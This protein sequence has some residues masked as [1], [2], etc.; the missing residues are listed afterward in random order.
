MNNTM[1]ILPAFFDAHTHT[2]FAAYDDDRNAVMA[3]A[4]DTGVWLIN[5]GTE[6]RTSAA[7]IA[8]AHRAHRGVWAT[9]GLHPLHAHESF[10]DAQELGPHPQGRETLEGEEFNYNTYKKLA[11]DPK[12]VG[13]GECGLDHFRMKDAAARAKQAEVF[14][15]HIEL[16]AEIKK[17]LM[18]HCREA[19]GDLISTLQATNHKL[20]SPP[21]VVHFFSGTKKDAK[22]LLDMEF[23][24]TF[25]G[26]VTFAREYDEVIR[27]LPLDHI[28][29]ETD[30]PYVSPAPYR[31]KRNEPVYI[32][33]TV[34][35]IADIRNEDLAMVAEALVKNAIRT[36]SIPMN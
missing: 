31:G 3:R 7:A 35:K 18:I 20:P 36:F 23:G 9:V 2:Q 13:I 21:G 29:S 28:L 4:R 22:K 30:A 16:S 24:F 25:G 33:E 34:K 8:S 10:H 5:V 1:S 32:V 15:A 26:V 14:R 27:Y 11:T 17:P 6:E 19:F 12:V